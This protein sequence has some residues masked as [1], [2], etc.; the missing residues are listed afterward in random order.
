MPPSP[1]THP[2]ASALHIPDAQNI[3]MVMLQF[4]L[5]SQVGVISVSIGHEVVP[6]TVPAG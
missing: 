6:H 2:V 5:P 3:C 1:G 4:P